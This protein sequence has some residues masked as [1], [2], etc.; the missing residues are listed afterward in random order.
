LAINTKFRELISEIE[1]SH[2]ND[3]SP[4]GIKVKEALITGFMIKPEYCIVDFEARKFNFKYLAGETYWY[5]LRNNSTEVIDMFSSFWKNIKNPDGTVNSNYGKIL[6]GKQMNWVINSLK[7]DRDTRQAIAYIGGPDFQFEGNKDFVCT[8]Y[9]LFFIRNNELHMKVQM[10]SN[11][12]AYGLMFDL[13]WFSTV[14]Q[15]VY[16]ELLETYPELQLGRYFHFSDNTHYYERHFETML[17]IIEEPITKP[18]IL[19]KLKQPLWIC[20]GDDTVSLTLKALE[21]CE[22]VEKNIENKDLSSDGW[23]QILKIIYHI[24]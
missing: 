24:E 15:N 20:N 14:M 2:G 16:Y 7:K 18:P 21:F 11:D 3:V 12:M 4:R 6:L 13:P 5:L 8:Q 17:K 1:A 23:K 10:R 22:E 19:L 9:L